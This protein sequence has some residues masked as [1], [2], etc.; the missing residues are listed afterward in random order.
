[1]TPT[2]SITA[3]SL[4]LRTV[5]DELGRTITVRQLTALDTL[6]LFKV[7]GPEL[8][9]NQ[10]WLSLA[11]LAFSVVEIDSV[12][13]P[14]PATEAQVERLVERLGDEGL[15]AIA[16]DIESELALSDHTDMTTAG[17]SHGTPT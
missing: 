10:P 4:T 7:A 3:R 9:R 15:N 11:T 17:N 2:D 5:V 12:P 16:D 6:R 8:A 14:A 1:M 13:V